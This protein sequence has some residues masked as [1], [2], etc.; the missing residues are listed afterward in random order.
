MSNGLG[1]DEIVFLL[2][3]L[4]GTCLHGI[5]SLGGSR[6]FSLTTFIENWVNASLELFVLV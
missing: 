3:M 6:C 4:L 5:V 2:A 1:I